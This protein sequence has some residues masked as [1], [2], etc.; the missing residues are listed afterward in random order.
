MASSD[1]LRAQLRAELRARLY[2]KVPVTR[3]EEVA[4]TLMSLPD[5]VTPAMLKTAG[6][7]MFNNT[8]ALASLDPETL[9]PIIAVIKQAELKERDVWHP[10]TT[11]QSSSPRPDKSR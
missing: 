5:G 7:V 2:G 8:N 6:A 9:N 4:D 1:K 11:S 3:L 10:A